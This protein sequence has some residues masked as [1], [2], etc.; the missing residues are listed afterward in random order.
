MEQQSSSTVETTRGRSHSGSNEASGTGEEPEIPAGRT[1]PLTAS[2]VTLVYLRQLARVL[3]LPTRCTKTKLLTAIEG[4]IGQG[5]EVLN[6]Q[7][8]IQ[9]T[10]GGETLFLVDEQGV[11]LDVPVEAAT[12]EPTR[13]T[14][15]EPTD[16]EHTIESLRQQNASLTQ[17]LQ[18]ATGRQGDQ[19]ATIAEQDAAIATL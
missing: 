16:L 5:H 2:K 9:K 10:E 17:A 1:L 18:E 13:T 19:D 11:F 3:S 8:I 7:V 14:R 15:S 4:E 12:Q 6:V